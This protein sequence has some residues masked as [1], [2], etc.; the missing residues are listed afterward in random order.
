M[1]HMVILLL[2]CD[3]SICVC[4]VVCQFWMSCACDLLVLLQNALTIVIQQ[5]CHRAMA[6]SV[7]CERLCQFVLDLISCQDW[8]GSGD[9]NLHW[10][11]E[12]LLV[13][14]VTCLKLCQQ[15]LCW[16]ASIISILLTFRP[17]T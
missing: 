5:Y 14:R 16:V 15:F 8:Y 3:Y 2:V 6:M 4:L 17:G 7:S 11:S 10:W 13:R 9:H 12:G 1:M